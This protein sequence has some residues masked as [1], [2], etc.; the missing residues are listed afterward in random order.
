MILYAA[1][2]VTLLLKG[3]LLSIVNIDVVM[4]AVYLY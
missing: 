2:I 3:A 4:I 1:V